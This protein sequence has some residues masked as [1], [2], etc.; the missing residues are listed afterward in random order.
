MGNRLDCTVNIPWIYCWKQQPVVLTLLN[1]GNQPH[2]GKLNSDLV[3]EWG[4]NPW[5]QTTPQLKHRMRGCLLHKTTPGPLASFLSPF[6]VSSSDMVFTYPTTVFMSNTSK[7][8][9]FPG[10]WRCKRWFS[11]HC[12]ASSEVSALYLLKITMTNECFLKHIKPNKSIHNNNFC[13]AP[14]YHHQQMTTAAIQCSLH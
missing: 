8:W 14:C 6:L 5:D 9:H 10:M 11:W 12:S 7:T 3:K 13:L 2:G 1:Q 4:F